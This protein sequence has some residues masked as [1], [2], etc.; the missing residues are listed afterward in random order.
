MR[1][2]YLKPSN[3]E[4]VSFLNVYF[5]YRSIILFNYILRNL[6]WIFLDID[7]IFARSFGDLF[8]LAQIVNHFLICNVKYADRIEV[9]SFPTVTMKIIKEKTILTNIFIPIDDIFQILTWTM[10]YTIDFV[11]RHFQQMTS[12]QILT[13][14]PIKTSY[15]VDN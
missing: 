9:D 12:Y 1:A 11:C 15:Y 5:I 3:Y 6:N 13:I 10:T 8:I 14:L 2:R 4:I 7:K